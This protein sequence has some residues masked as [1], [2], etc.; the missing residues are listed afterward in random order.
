VPPPPESS[1]QI[2]LRLP[3]TAYLAVVLLLL[4]T[5]PLAFGSND[6][7]SVSDIAR[8]TGEGGGFTIGWR[9]VFL[10]IPV[11]LALG[12]ARTTTIV[13]ADGIRVRALFGTRTMRWDEL[14]GLS[15]SGR[16]VYAVLTDGAVRLPCARLAH[17]GIISRTSD[18]RLPEL[19]DPVA[20]PAPARRSRR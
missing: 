17:L 7:R 20:K 2:V 3:R 4:G 1:A 6:Y 16:G 19:P 12:I 9:L 14:R 15:V 10:L 8:G 5:V 11:L 13:N 18:G